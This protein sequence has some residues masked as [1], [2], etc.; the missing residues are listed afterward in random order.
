M[1]IASGPFTGSPPSD[2]SHYYGNIA[3]GG[4]DDSE[5]LELLCYLGISL[6]DPRKSSVK[7][8]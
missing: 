8:G 4:T 2:Q 1:K 3:C 6:K 5:C 7:Y